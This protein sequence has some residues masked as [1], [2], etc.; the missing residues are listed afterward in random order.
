MLNIF[1]A[2]LVG[3][4]HRGPNMH[5]VAVSIHICVY[6]YTYTHRPEKKTI[7]LE[8]AFKLQIQ[9]EVWFLWLPESVCCWM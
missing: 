3:P 7:L 2:W 5:K 8:K 1:D 9:T 4:L 6:V